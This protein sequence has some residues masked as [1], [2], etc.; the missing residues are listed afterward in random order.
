MFALDSIFIEFPIHAII[1]FFSLKNFI[2]SRSDLEL[3]N[4]YSSTPGPFDI[5]IQLQMQIMKEQIFRLTLTF[6]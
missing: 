2:T 6:L 1:L 5:I 4:L 3:Y